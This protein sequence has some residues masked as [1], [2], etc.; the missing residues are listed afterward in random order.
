MGLK[1][2]RKSNSMRIEATNYERVELPKHDK[3]KD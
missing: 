3:D 2:E 1:S